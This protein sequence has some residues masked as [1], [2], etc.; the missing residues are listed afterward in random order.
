MLIKLHK[1]DLGIRPIIN[2]IL[3]P[4]EKISSL[5]DLLL[6]PIIQKCDSYV[7][8]SQHLLQICENLELPENN[9]LYTFDFVALYTNMQ[10]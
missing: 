10:L 1:K 8:D 9:Y 3:H 2:S 7:Q 5:I 4:T 6:K